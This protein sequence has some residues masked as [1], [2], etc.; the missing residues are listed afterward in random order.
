MDGSS[1]MLGYVSDA[2][3]R[4]VQTLKLLDETLSLAGKTPVQYYRSGSPIARGDFRKAQLPA[5]YNGTNFPDVSVPIQNLVSPPSDRDSLLVIVTDLDQAS[6]DVTLLTR[7]IKETYLN[8][9]NPEF[10]IGILAIKSEFAGTVYVQGQQNLKT[11]PFPNEESNEEFRPFY[12][13]FL[14]RPQD[15]ITTIQDLKKREKDLFENSEIAIFSRNNLVQ[16]TALLD[17]VVKEEPAKEKAISGKMFFSFNGA[18]VQAKDE[19]SQFWKIPSTEKVTIQDSVPVEM[20]ENT[21]PIDVNSIDLVK[22]IEVP[23]K[24]TKTFEDSTKVYKD[25]SA[26]RRAIEIAGWNLDTE[27]QNNPRE[28]N[29]ETTIRPDKF[30]E[31]GIYLFSIDI[32]ARDLQEQPW[33]QEWNWK[34]GRDPENDGS[35]TNNLLPFLR[36]LKKITTDLMADN[37]PKIGRFCYAIEKN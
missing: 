23:N 29:F 35:K 11:F 3:S 27:S 21:V 32:V 15:I 36:G 25:D 9:Q 31:P 14:G 33:W 7:K 17:R 8:S 18:E 37:P 1:S 30:P 22:T 10:A 19:R 6:G 12:V 28:L 16:N 34:V 5:F 4:Y 2:N 20:S 24:F 26:L 13:I